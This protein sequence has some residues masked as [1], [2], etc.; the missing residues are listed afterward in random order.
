MEPITSRRNPRILELVRLRRPDVRREM[1]R[2]LVEGR[3]ESLRAHRN[4]LEILGIFAT[5]AALKEWDELE[6]LARS[7]PL[8]PV[9]DSVFEKISA[10]ENPDGLLCVAATPPNRFPAALPPDALVVVAER[11]EK[12]GNLGALL[13]TMEAAGCDLLILADPLTDLWNPHAIRA[14]QG[15]IFAVPA[16]TCSSGEALRFLRANGVTVV[17]TAPAAPRSYWDA[18]PAGPLAIVAGNE[19]DGLGNFWLNAADLAVHIP[20][21]G[22][23]S[24]SLNVTT[25]TALCLYEAL[26]RRGQGQ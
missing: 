17:A 2:F 9:S 3:R 26:R 6:E 10:R 4:S 1:G 11:L 23:T 7:A 25:A 24:D 20:M 13:R 5:A 14:S 12:P 8:F 16:V 22:G 19:H 18:L 21:R 15:A